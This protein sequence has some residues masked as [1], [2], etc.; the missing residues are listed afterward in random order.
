MFQ[1]EM[2]V[3][4]QVFSYSFLS[5]VAE[6]GGYAGMFFGISLYDFSVMFSMFEFT[7]RNVFKALDAVK[8]I[9]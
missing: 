5:L 4:K 9:L 8:G 6:I 3:S 2:M 1:S 7:N